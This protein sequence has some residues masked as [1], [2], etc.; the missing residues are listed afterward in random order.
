ML[1]ECESHRDVCPIVYN[2]SDI[3]L[4]RDPS[5]GALQHPGYIRCIAPD[6]RVTLDA[7]GMPS[8]GM[9]VVKDNNGS[10]W[11]ITVELRCAI[12]L[13]V[14]VNSWRSGEDNPD[15]PL[16]FNVLVLDQP[17]T[18]GGLFIQCRMSQLLL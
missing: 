13:T 12:N 17:T 8:E 16:Y 6:F 4:Y 9:Q 14:T 3:L 2:N 11:W 1:L 7:I 15:P 5:N 18:S 10:A